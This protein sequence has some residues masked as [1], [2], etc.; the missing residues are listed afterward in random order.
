MTGLKK[1]GGLGLTSITEAAHERKRR[2]LLE[3]VNK[4]GM[5]G[6][7]TQCLV[8]NALRAAGQGGIGVGGVHI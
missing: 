4:G 7:A 5:D 3:L 6:I 2:V 8:A 1:H